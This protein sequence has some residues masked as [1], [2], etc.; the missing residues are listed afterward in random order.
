MPQFVKDAT[1]IVKGREAVE[2]PLEETALPI[3]SHNA[4]EPQGLTVVLA[5][6]EV[7]TIR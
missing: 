1:L 4:H 6:A 5:N 2:I 3:A 7:E